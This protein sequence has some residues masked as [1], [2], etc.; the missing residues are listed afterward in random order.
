MAP[1]RALPAP[2]V[3]HGRRRQLRR[4]RKYCKLCY[5]KGSSMVPTI[6]AQ[7][8]VG[9]LDRRCLAGYDFSRGDVVVFRLSTDHGMK[10][11]Q[12]MIALP[13]DW[14]QIPE[15][16]DIRQVPSGHC[17]VEGDN[18]GNSWDSRHYGPVPLDLMEG[19]ITHIIWP[20][21]RV[22]RVDRMVPEGRIMPLSATP[23]R[24]QQ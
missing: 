20:P 23:R 2:L 16:R 4:R 8:D 5:L 13:G 6:Q 14:I 22:R 11:V 9:L 7:G 12:R 1:A 17:W 15:K 10:M 18:A 19:K 21:H 24:K 3:V